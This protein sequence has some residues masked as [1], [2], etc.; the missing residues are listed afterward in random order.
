MKKKTILTTVIAFL[1]LVAVIAAGINAIY[2]VTYVRATFR[3]YTERGAAA[4]EQLKEELNGYINRSSTFLSLA[5][6]RATVEANPRFEVVEIY[7]DYP[8]TVV[9]EVTERR[10]AFAVAAED[11]S[12]TV[13]GE[14]GHVLGSVSSAEGYILLEGFVLS[15]EGGRASGTDFDRLLAMYGALRTAFGEVRANL[16]SVTRSTPAKLTNFVLQMRE[17]A[18]LHFYLP[19][20]QTAE[21]AERMAALA[22]ER[23][24]GLSDAE[25]VWCKITMMV[26][27]NGQLVGPDVTSLGGTA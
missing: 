23:Y 1:L 20:G 22:A 21:T 10:E 7:K 16:L 24:M 8:E 19:E 2:T 9:V 3:T 17:G 27:E 26:N 15:F 13:L 25:R 5:D 4:A 12:Y 18:Q 6:V 11:G 14:D